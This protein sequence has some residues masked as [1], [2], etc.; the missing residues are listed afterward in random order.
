MLPQAE[1]GRPE[2]GTKSD[3]GNAIVAFQYQPEANGRAE[4]L[5]FRIPG[6]PLAPAQARQAIAES[7]LQAGG[8]K[9][10][11]ELLLLTSEVV[12]NAVEH[13]HAD[14]NGVIELG[15][16]LEPSRV[17]VDVADHGGGFIPV[18][19]TNRLDEPGG[20]G[21]FLVDLLADRWG[22]QRGDSTQVWFELTL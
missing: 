2:S 5:V 13:G 8:S 21:L 22:V 14:D 6:G 10:A 11:L 1:H 15:V 7:L 4:R 17:K 16:S 3:S 12:T 20:W 9:V 18:R 19:R